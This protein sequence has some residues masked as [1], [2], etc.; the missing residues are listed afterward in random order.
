MDAMA[1]PGS[2]ATMVGLLADFAASRGQRDVLDTKEFVEWLRVHGHSELIARIE[3]NAAVTV[4]IKAALAEGKDELLARLASIEALLV[5]LSVDSGGLNGL[6]MALSPER[7]ISPQAVGILRAYDDAGAGQALLVSNFEDDILMFLDGRSSASFQPTERRFFQADL[8][9]LVE[10]RLLA[11]DHNKRS[12]RIYELT[13]R[14]AAVARS[15]LR[16]LAAA[17]AA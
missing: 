5:A 10:H 4:G 9:E 16:V 7:A 6:A 13:R 3:Q 2:F 11:L 14:G 1:W 8:R 17:G 12:D 15:T